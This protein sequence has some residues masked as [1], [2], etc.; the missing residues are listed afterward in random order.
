MRDEADRVALEA[1]HELHRLIPW[2]HEFR[3]GKRKCRIVELNGGE[4]RSAPKIRMVDPDCTSPVPT[5]KP[6]GPNAYTEVLMMFDVEVDGSQIDHVE[7]TMK[8]TGF[9]GFVSAK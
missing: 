1:M 9:G 5:G 6:P 2:G 8:R 3:V 7:I 4:G